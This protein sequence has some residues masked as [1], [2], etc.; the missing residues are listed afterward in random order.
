M[1]NGY[2]SLS[3]NGKY[4]VINDKCKVCIPAI[5]TGVVE[6]YNAGGYAV[7]LNQR[8][9]EVKV[10]YEGR[11]IGYTEHQNQL[12]AE[13]KRQAEA[14]EKARLAEEARKAEERRIADRNAAEVRQYDALKSCFDN[15]QN[16]AFATKYDEYMK[17]YA[18]DG[19][20]RNE[21]KKMKETIKSREHCIAAGKAFS[22]WRL[23]NQVC[24]YFEDAVIFGL[25]EQFNDDRSSVQV[26]IT[27]CSRDLNSYKA[28]NI[29]KDGTIW[30]QPV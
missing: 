11:E 20:H 30:V 4:G 10:N 12:F 16:T 18:S 26:K 28:Q 22:K 6:P 15:F 5:Y 13:A 2:A 19:S 1:Q 21:I 27:A 7:L 17:E 9:E 8:G 14:A 29:V 3:L 24:V 23:G 25:V